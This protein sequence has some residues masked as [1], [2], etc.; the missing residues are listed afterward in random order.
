MAAVSVMQAQD[1]IPALQPTAAQASQPVQKTSLS[2]ARDSIAVKHSALRVALKTNAFGIMLLEPNLGVELGIA[3]RVSVAVE[4]YR[5]RWRGVFN[6][7]VLLDA[8]LWSADARYWL[9][10]WNKNKPGAFRGHFLGAYYTEGNVDIQ[11][12]GKGNQAIVQSYGLEY[13]YVMPLAKRL[14]LEMCVGAG[15][16]AADYDHYRLSNDGE[17]LNYQYSGRTNWWGPTKA[18][19]SLMFVF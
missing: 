4:V 5:P 8:N 1:T 15:Y 13:G 10:R 6:N 17:T 9:R 7:S 14:R 3:D 16:L 19:L 2:S 18:N 11:S 12:K